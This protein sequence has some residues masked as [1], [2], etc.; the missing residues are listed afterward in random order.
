MGGYISDNFDWHL[1]FNIN[2]PVGIFCFFATWIIQR[3]Y[4]LAKSHPFD[5]A[6]FLSL[7]AFLGFL[8]V[9]LASGNSEWNS[10]GWTSPF[11][12]LCYVCS[13][14]GLVVF[15]IVEFNIEYPLVR[16]R[17]LGH[18]NF[19]LSNMVMFIFGIGMFGSVFLIPLYLQNILGYTALQSGMVL[20][21]VGIIQAI[22]GPIGGY[23]SDKVNPKIPI[24]IGI[25]LFTISFFLN[26]LLSV[27]SEHAQIM[28]PMYLRGSPWACFSRRSARFPS[29][30]SPAAT[31]R[32]LP[33][34]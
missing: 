34:S 23:F 29:R 3:E 28:L 20:L 5:V 12:M 31:W 22:C 18:Y 33:D 4:K 17:L 24:C 15:L 6:G 1:I 9:A 19:G 16:L 8:L 26:S 30:K 32:R 21:P 7:S 14:I 11:M 13:F 2:V 10:G 25:V 27:F